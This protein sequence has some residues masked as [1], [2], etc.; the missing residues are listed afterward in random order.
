MPDPLLVTGLPA[1]VPGTALKIAPPPEP[2]PVPVLIEPEPWLAEW[3][4]ALR[5]PVVHSDDPTERF[6]L[7]ALRQ[8]QPVSFTYLGGS[9]PGMVRDVHP[10]LL[11]RLDGYRS[12]YLTAYCQLRQE[13]RTFRLD[14]VYRVVG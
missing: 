7:R 14:R 8:N 12:A 1:A 10:V 13:I 2:P 6:F 3:Q 5:I 11:F 4:A 9:A